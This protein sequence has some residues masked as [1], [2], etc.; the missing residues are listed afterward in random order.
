MTGCVL[1]K[2]ILFLELSDNGFLR[3]TSLSVNVLSGF[4]PSSVPRKHR[5]GRP[6]RSPREG[7]GTTSAATC[8]GPDTD[9]QQPLF[10]G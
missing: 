6:L 9:G 4:V 2:P 7:A 1:L 3:N 5:R 10:P 8:L